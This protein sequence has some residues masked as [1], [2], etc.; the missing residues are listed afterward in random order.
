M[1][2][3]GLTCD[4]FLG[5][6]LR[7]WQPA[8]GYRAGVDPVVLAAAVPVRAG[9]TV[10]E[11]G[12]GVG[13]AAL[14]LL[15]RVPGAR[16]TGLEVQPDYAA[17]AERNAAENNT[18]LTLVQG[19]LA[20]MPAELRAQSFDHVIANPPYFERARGTA[21]ADAGRDTALAGD[22][23]LIAWMD[24]AARR[25][26]PGGRLTVI[27]RA[28]RLDDLLKACDDRLGHLRLLPLA[29]REGR[30]AERVLLH[31]RKGGRGALRLLAPVILH[32]GARHERDGDDYSRTARAVLR[33]GAALPVDWS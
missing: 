4:G 32:D 26:K 28:E 33:E 31:A 9:E 19:D 20:Q 1:D 16:V 25:L 27:Q 18:L 3:A 23:P 10:L 29:A 15:A 24:A 7:I 30:A 5:G 13:T 8:K 22:T 21:A 6:S 17:L 11:L 2:D 14:C 12:C